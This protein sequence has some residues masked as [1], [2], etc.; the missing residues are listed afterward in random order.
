VVVAP[1]LE[2]LVDVPDI[3]MREL[4]LVLQI[5][6][7]FLRKIFRERGCRKRRTLSLFT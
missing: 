3:E 6:E 4:F 5:I 7:I 1:V 2:L